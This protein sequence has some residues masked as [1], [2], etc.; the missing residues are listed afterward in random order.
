VRGVAAAAAD[1]RYA[2]SAHIREANMNKFL[3]AVLAAGLATQAYAQAPAPQQAPATQPAPQNQN[4]ECSANNEATNQPFCWQKNQQQDPRQQ[5]SQ[6]QGVCPNG[7]KPL[8]DGNCPAPLPGA[9]GA[10][11]AASGAPNGALIAGVVV[12]VIAVAALA[13]GGSSHNS[14]TT[15]TH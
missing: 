12:G 15:G 8:A 5:D 13:G 2:W 7:E 6:Q 3:V 9:G 4:V 14:G 10:T 11:A 1:L